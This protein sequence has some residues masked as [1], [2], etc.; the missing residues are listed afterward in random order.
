MLDIARMF[1]ILALNQCLLLHFIWNSI[2]SSEVLSHSTI[3][4]LSWHHLFW[5][6]MQS[7]DITG[8]AWISKSN[9]NCFMKNMMKLHVLPGFSE[10]PFKLHS[11]QQSF[12]QFP[13]IIFIS[14]WQGGN[15]SWLVNF[16][17]LT[18]IHTTLNFI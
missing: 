9:F 16:V 17:H 18:Y 7:H 1:I 5:G 15:S 12:Q 6:L 11:Y 10:S 2:T 3:P 13:Q 14:Q 8:T 4:F